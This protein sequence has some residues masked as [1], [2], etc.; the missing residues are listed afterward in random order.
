MNEDSY[1]TAEEIKVDA[2]LRY[3]E[4][5]PKLP[6]NL[7]RISH[8]FANVA[9]SMIESV[10]RSAERTAGLRKLLEAKDCFVRAALDEV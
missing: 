1:F 2:I 3:L 5:N 10:P 6:E 8:R 4:P 9:A 7:A